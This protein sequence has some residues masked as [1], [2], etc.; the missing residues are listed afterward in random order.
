MAGSAEMSVNTGRLMDEHSAP[1][2]RSLSVQK[3]GLV[4]YSAALELQQS[5][6]EQR[7]RGEIGD[8]LL[9]LEHP[10][11]ITLGARNRVGAANVIASAS[12]LARVGI[13]VQETGR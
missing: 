3:R 9:L 5:L 4:D 12:E 8:T 13:V 2:Q 7:R 6:V 1:S 10:S 11:V